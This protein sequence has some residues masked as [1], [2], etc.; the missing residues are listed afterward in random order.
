MTLIIETLKGRPQERA[1]FWFLRQAGR[2][3][4]E[5]R[6]VRAQAG[7]FLDLVFNPE[8]ATEVTLQPIRRF[9]PDA[10]I[11]FSDILVTPLA[12][13]QDLWFEQGEGPRL[14]PLSE[15]DWRTKLD[16]AKAHDCLAPIYETVERL[17]TA[18]PEP[19]SLIGFA[20]SPWTVATYMVAGRGTKDQGPARDM[21]YRDPEAFAEVIERLEIVTVDYLI[22]Q[23][24]A[25]AEAV[26]LFD[27]WAG[28]LPPD[29]FDL[30]VTQPT[31][32]IVEKLRAAVDVPVIGFPRG[33]GLNLKSY[34][35]TGVD[36]MHID[37]TVPAAW[38]AEHLQPHVCIQGNLDPR[39]P[40]IGGDAMTRAADDA[41]QALKS[42]AHVVNLGHGITPDVP[43]AH[44][45]ALAAHLK[46]SRR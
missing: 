20:G 43:P 29:Q 7:G 38:A 13:G 45:E 9:S 35:Q 2:Y 32:R 17:T 3:M 37:E 39:L 10:A 22:R 21:A 1:P 41:L 26:M 11:L 44:I 36:A 16:P 34:L 24:K 31:K 28:V 42:G 6:E 4:D 46:S 18:L 23:V 15:F 8:L 33:G 14:T 19:V 5:Y 12:L 27:S 40:L 30:W 25:G